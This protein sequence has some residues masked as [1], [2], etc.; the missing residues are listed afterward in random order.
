MSYQHTEK[1]FFSWAPQISIKFNEHID[2]MQGK[3][4][5]PQLNTLCNLFVTGVQNLNKVH[6]MAH[7]HVPIV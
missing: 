5:N 2:R 3:V 1:Q 4:P 7:L 6:F